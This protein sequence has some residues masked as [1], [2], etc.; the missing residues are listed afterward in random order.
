M[1]ANSTA[2]IEQ[3]PYITTLQKEL[4]NENPSLQPSIEIVIIGLFNDYDDRYWDNPPSELEFRSALVKLLNRFQ[5]VAC[6][7]IIPSESLSKSSYTGENGVSFERVSLFNSISR[8]LA[9]LNVHIYELDDFL[10]NEER[11]SITDSRHYPRDVWMKVGEQ[12]RSD[13]TK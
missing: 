10:S 12:L 13:F 9:D 11:S 4:K 1:G 3:W 2:K 8:S 6:I 5:N 7:L